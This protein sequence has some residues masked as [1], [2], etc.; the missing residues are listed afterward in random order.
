MRSN[1]YLS[2]IRRS[3][4]FFGIVLFLAF[5]FFVAWFVV[6]TGEE[7]VNKTPQSKIYD[8]QKE[9]QK[10]LEGKK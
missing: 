8:T 10:M 3:S 2:G 9:A 7:I 6:R 1:S 4:V 5:S